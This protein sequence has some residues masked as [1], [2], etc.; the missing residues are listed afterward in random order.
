MV[1]GRCGTEMA[2]GSVV[3]KSCGCGWCM[4]VSGVQA[5]SE[6]DGRRGRYSGSALMQGERE[7]ER[8][9]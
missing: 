9:V 7:R 3:K 2:Q 6:E 1:L 5:L 4:A 8:E